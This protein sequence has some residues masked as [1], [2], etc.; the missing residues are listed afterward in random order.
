MKKDRSR[1]FD[2]HELI[3]RKSIRAEERLTKAVKD[4]SI[5]HELIGSLESETVHSDVNEL[6]DDLKVDIF[7][8]YLGLVP[9]DK[10]DS[11]PQDANSTVGNKSEMPNANSKSANCNSAS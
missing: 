6:S 4:K 7:E 11:E 2:C 9:S 5:V 10:I 3:A 1:K 8:E